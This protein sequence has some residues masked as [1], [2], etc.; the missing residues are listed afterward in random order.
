MTFTKGQRR[1]LKALVIYSAF[2]FVAGLALLAYELYSTTLNDSATISQTIWVI[3]AHQPWA[4]LA[5]VLGVGGILIFLLSHFTSQSDKVYDAIRKGGGSAAAILLAFTLAG[6]EAIKGHPCAKDP[7]GCIPTPVPT[8]APTPT[9][10]PTPTP[11]PVPSVSPSPTPTPEPT[12][13]PSP[14]PTP[15]P[16]PTPCPTAT[17]DPGCRPCNGA[18]GFESIGY[19]P[20]KGDP[21]FLE[22]DNCAAGDAKACTYVS[23]V[24][25]EI[26]GKPFPACTL[27]NSR[28][29]RRKGGSP[30]EQGICVSTPS[31]SPRPVE[32]P[33]PCPS[34]SATPPPAGDPTDVDKLILAHYDKA[35][36]GCKNGGLGNQRVQI[37]RGCD[38][39]YITATPKDETPPCAVGN[40]D[41]QRHTFN[42][43]WYVGANCKDN[44]GGCVRVAD[45]G[46][47][48]GVGPATVAAGRG[49]AAEINLFNR[50]IFC[51]RPGTFTLWGV[52]REP[53]GIYHF[54]RPVDCW[55]IEPA[56]K[57]EPGRRTP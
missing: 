51:Q 45:D 4:I 13:T 8:P 24:A 19:A 54:E 23:R 43:A 18:A 21:R 9:P 49:H 37:P 44:P 27:F 34:P 17:V 7:L 42:L 1:T 33:A 35:G 41:S 25:V 11:S 14:V 16:S 50:L 2:Q 6:C 55:L 47:E 29:Q 57:A 12:P 38:E 39:A 36:E 15:T 22:M 20:K 52:L 32:S 28:M 30:E 48:T 31:P 56:G 26:D 40:C 53:Q 10:E 5:V 46:S 3:W